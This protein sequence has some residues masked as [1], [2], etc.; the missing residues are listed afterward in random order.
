MSSETFEFPGGDGAALTGR[1][2]PPVGEAEGYALFAHC[3]AC[4]ETGHAA[5]RTARALALCG[6]G[7]LR[8]DFTGLGEDGDSE[9]RS[10]G[11]VAD[12]LAA[13]RA[14]AGAGRSPTLLVG[15]SVGGAAVL[16]AAL[17]LPDV[18]AVAVIGAPYDADHLAKIVGEGE[19]RLMSEGQADADLGGKPF[20]LHRS[21]V[22]SLR[23]EDP[24]ARIARLRRPLLVMHSPL[25]RAVDIDN[26]TKIFVA[27]RHPKS[28]ISLDRAD[29]LLSEP[30][31]AEYVA[32]TILAWAS[33]YLTPTI[34]LRGEGEESRVIVEETGEGG[35]QVEVLAGRARFLSDEPV[36]VGGMGSGPTP[37]D[38]LGA[39][40]G[41]CTAMTLRL[42]ARGKGWPVESV[43][44]SVGHAK[45][46]GHQIPDIFTR[47]IAICGELTAEQRARLLEIADRC[48]VHRTL[49]RGARIET[50]ET[51]HPRQLP[52]PDAPAAH[53][54][55]MAS[56]SA[57][58]SQ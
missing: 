49:E 15:H 21:L 35:F 55:D 20:P 5:A 8:I 12:I 52:S 42:Y 23:A 32:E 18:R 39:A 34:A 38:L 43:R 16:A 33:R 46:P 19:A 10:G 48:P 29:H 14:M 51:T 9:R 36:A 1:Y 6:F 53:A 40:L 54:Q 41:A 50:S 2:E 24:G 4:S 7:V 37:Y 3:F 25:D 27:A 56:A 17:D 31:D 13:A 45:T 47:E 28:F 30:V 22:Q 44:V 57:Q 58:D 26:A 11:D